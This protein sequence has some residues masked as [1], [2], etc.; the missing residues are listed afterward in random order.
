MKNIDI[1]RRLMNNTTPR[2]L[3]TPQI[4]DPY[5]KHLL[6]EIMDTKFPFA[7]HDT[8]GVYLQKL[9]RSL[10]TQNSEGYIEFCPHS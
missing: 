7:K 4:N 5:T 2:T 6:E 8:Y 9:N 10:S 3:E 1:L